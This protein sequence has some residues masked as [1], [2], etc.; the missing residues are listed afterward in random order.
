MK[1]SDAEA[2]RANKFN[3]WKEPVLIAILLYSLMIIFFFVSKFI[4]KMEILPFFSPVVSEWADFASYVANMVNPIIALYVLYFVVKTYRLQKL[5]FGK[6]TA[7][8]GNQIEID[9]SLRRQESLMKIC[10]HQVTLAL[11]H[12]ASQTSVDEDEV[13]E[14]LFNA[15]ILFAIN[16]EEITV[17]KLLNHAVTC[18]VRGDYNDK[19][20]DLKLPR[21]FYYLINLIK[22]IDGICD[23]MQDIDR[24]LQ[25]ISK[26]FNFTLS[27]PVINSI[28]AKIKPIVDK[29]RTLKVF[30]TVNKDVLEHF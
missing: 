4:L 29:F 13:Y 18:A 12:L 6:T 22:S 2:F 5:E 8:L 21:D 28:N 11:D 16:T 14:T 20:K 25:Q 19:E 9:S 30:V 3:V 26:T 17:V 23:E 1:K 24:R 27:T 15:D 10:D 7:I